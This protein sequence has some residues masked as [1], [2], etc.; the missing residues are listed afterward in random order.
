MSFIFSFS[1]IAAPWAFDISHTAYCLALAPPLPSSPPWSSL[2]TT[3]ASAWALPTA[4]W[5]QVPASSQWAS[6]F[7][8][9]RWWNLLASAGP[10]RSSASSCLFRPCWRSLSNLCYLPEEAW[11]HQAW[12]L[13][14]LTPKPNK[15]PR[16][17]EGT[18]VAGPW[19]GSRSTLTCE[20]FTSSRTGCGH[21]ELQQLYWATLCRMSTW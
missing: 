6:Q 1:H 18:G 14:L 11:D 5:Q 8:S 9:T 16:L 21:L 10:S 7:C 19:P 17:K 3:S 13:A 2:A 15:G 4:W 20:C 12:V